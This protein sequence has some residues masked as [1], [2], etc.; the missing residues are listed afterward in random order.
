MSYVYYNADT[1][2]H[3]GTTLT[4]VFPVDLYD[5]FIMNYLKI[6][7]PYATR[8]DALSE[9]SSCGVFFYE[10]GIL[11]K[12]MRTGA[13][14]YKPCEDVECNFGINWHTYYAKTADR[15]REYLTERYDTLYNF[16]PTLNSLGLYEIQV[17]YDGR[18]R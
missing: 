4:G 5:R 7:T 3:P 13:W 16:T 1:M 9:T 8:E 12:A 14:Q 18:C 6:H 10:N 11:Y 2:Q 17:H 15:L